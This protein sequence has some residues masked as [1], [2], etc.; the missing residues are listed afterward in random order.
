[1]YAFN[2][3]EMFAAE[4]P[5]AVPEPLN[6]LRWLASL[7]PEVVQVIASADAGIDTISDLKGKRI[8]VGAPGSGHEA[9]A[10]QILMAHGFSYDDFA[11][12]DFI[13]HTEAGDAIK[14]G[15]LDAYFTT[16]GIPTASAV[17]IFSTHDVKLVRV[18]NEMA[19]NIVEEWP[20]YAKFTIPAGTYSGQDEPVE[21][22][23][24]MAALLINADVDEDLAY[25]LT[26]ALFENLDVMAATHQ[27]G[28]D[29]TLEGAL[30][31][32]AL[33]LHPGVAKYYEEVGALNK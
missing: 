11:R 14:D 18:E 2:Q 16:A 31:G 5:S 25:N 32:Q 12:V 26:K 1:D 8:A 9:N 19:E 15:H 30:E 6:K 29:I 27:R 28:A 17:D 13:M 33:E 3:E 24:V 4:G 21:T 10:R 22:L 7:Y 20:F 23:A